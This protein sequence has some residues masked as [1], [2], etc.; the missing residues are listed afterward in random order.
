MQ[1]TKSDITDALKLRMFVLKFNLSQVKTF[2][3]HERIVEELDAIEARLFDEDCTRLKLA[4]FISNPPIEDKSEY[5]SNPFIS[6][7]SNRFS[8]LPNKKSYSLNVTQ[9]TS[10]A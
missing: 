4:T 6:Y 10:A 2:P 8:V 3:D 9:A 7:A 1:L 5:N